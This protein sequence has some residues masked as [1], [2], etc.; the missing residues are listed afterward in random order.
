MRNNSVRANNL[1]ILTFLILSFVVVIG[2]IF[3]PAKGSYYLLAISI[4]GGFYFLYTGIRKISQIQQQQVHW[5]AQ[6][7]ILLGIAFLIALPWNLLRSG[8]LPV[9]P[10]SMLIENVLTILILILFLIAYYLFFRGILRK[11]GK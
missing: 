7:S 1:V 10:N 6:P 5:Y 8:I 4:L 3:F 2:I 11:I 9:F